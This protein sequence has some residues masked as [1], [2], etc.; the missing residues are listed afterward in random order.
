MKTPK[1]YI[2]T[3]LSLLDAVLLK[4]ITVSRVKCKHANIPADGYLN[5]YPMW[6]NPANNTYVVFTRYE[7]ETFKFDGINAYTYN[8]PYIVGKHVNGL[9]K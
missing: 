8:L 2:N 4:M 9:N 7:I 1:S 3:G 5:D 6:Y